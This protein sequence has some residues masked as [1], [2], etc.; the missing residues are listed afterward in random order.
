MIIVFTIPQFLYQWYRLVNNNKTQITELNTMFSFFKLA[1]FFFRSEKLTQLFILL[2]N[3]VSTEISSCTLLL[4]IIKRLSL[5]LINM[6]KVSDSFC[7]VNVSKL[8]NFKENIIRGVFVLY[9]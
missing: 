1:M 7:I 5:A 8:I 3:V 4:V 2:Y 9:T 6:C